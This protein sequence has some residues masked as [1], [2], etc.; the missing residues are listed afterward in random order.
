MSSG[1]HHRFADDVILVSTNIGQQTLVCVLVYIVRTRVFISVSKA[2]S[3]RPDRCE[4]LA[5]GKL[6]NIK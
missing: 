5:K 1:L 3:G 2:S 4:V 6:L